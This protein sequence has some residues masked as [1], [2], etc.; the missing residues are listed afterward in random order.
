MSGLVTG[1]GDR[2]T[3]GGVH[4][5]VAS[6]GDHSAVDCPAPTLQLI[7]LRR[8]PGELRDILPFFLARLAPL[9]ICFR[10]AHLSF[11]ECFDRRLVSVRICVCASSSALTRII[12]TIQLGGLVG[13]R[14]LDRSCNIKPS[15]PPCAER[16]S[17]RVC[18]H[19]GEGVAIQHHRRQ[20]TYRPTGGSDCTGEC[21]GETRCVIYQHIIALSNGPL[22]RSLSKDGSSIF[23]SQC[24]HYL[25][26]PTESILNSMHKRDTGGSEHYFDDEDWD[27]ASEEES[28]PLTWSLGEPAAFCDWSIEVTTRIANGKGKNRVK[29]EGSN[30]KISQPSVQVYHVHKAILSSGRRRSEYFTTLFK[31]SQYN[32][33]ESSTSRIQ[34]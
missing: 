2:L 34:L 20:Y 15:Q 8:V 4:L 6:E 27:A 32:E 33:F 29:R 5:L 19:P 12:E 26:D 7:S 14:K 18:H 16:K 3:V 28:E 30:V 22:D 23:S 31:Q 13:R 25:G 17:G 9:R 1:V 21:D 24:F 11:S 10:D